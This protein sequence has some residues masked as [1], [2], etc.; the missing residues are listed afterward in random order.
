MSA[1]LSV[2]SDREVISLVNPIWQSMNAA[3]RARARA[4]AEFDVCVR[5]SS[6]GI[7]SSPP[8]SLPL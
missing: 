3:E 1:Q 8:G 4:S 6:S 7:Q 5:G 2:K